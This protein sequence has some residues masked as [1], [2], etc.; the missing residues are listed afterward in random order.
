M[1]TPTRKQQRR[2]VETPPKELELLGAGEA[3]PWWCCWWGLEGYVTEEATQVLDPPKGYVRATEATVC[4]HG[5]CKGLVQ[6]YHRYCPAC[7][8]ENENFA[9]IA[10]AVAKGGKQKGYKRKATPLLN[11]EEPLSLSPTKIKQ[12]KAWQEFGGT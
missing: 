10:D 8:G 6:P 1:D 12:P 3:K 7:R 5:Q 11:M 2:E 4:K 9:P